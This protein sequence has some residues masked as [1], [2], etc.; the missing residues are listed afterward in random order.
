MGGDHASGWLPL[1]V[2]AIGLTGIFGG[3][4][5]ACGERANKPSTGQPF[6]TGCDKKHRPSQAVNGL[7]DRGMVLDRLRT[8]PE[9][10]SDVRNGDPRDELMG[11]LG[12]GWGVG[13][14]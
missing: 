6:R 11:G 4:Q 13:G 9:K 10:P 1:L 3:L 14:R 7:P 12:W 8:L 2:P 5:S